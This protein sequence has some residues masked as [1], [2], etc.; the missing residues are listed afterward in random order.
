[1]EYNKL[2]RDGIPEK[3]D[4][5]GVPYVKRIASEEEYRFELIKKLKEE[6]SEFEEVGDIEELADILE[7]IDALKKLPEYV[8]VLEVQKQKREERGGFE[9]R[10]I[11]KGQKD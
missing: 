6:T 4:N 9:N 8:N 3:L 7:V 1:M 11:L 10:L 5:L 2:V